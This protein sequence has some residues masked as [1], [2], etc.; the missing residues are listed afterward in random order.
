MRIGKASPK[1]YSSLVELTSHEGWNYSESDFLRLQSTGC[2]ETIV[3][4]E[5]GLVVGMITIMDYGDVAWIANVVVRSDLRGMG[6]GKALMDDAIARN[7]GKKTIA[8]LSYSNTVGFYKK[9]GF[10][11]E[12]KLSH[13]V[14]KGGRAGSAKE[15]T[16]SAD[17]ALDQRCFG[18]R[19]QGVLEMMMREYRALSPVK[20]RGFAFVRPDPV[21]PMVGPVIAD[22]KE[23]GEDL[24]YAALSMGG[25]GCGAVTPRGGL[26]HTE[27][28]AS[29]SMLYLGEKP[30]LDTGRVYALAGL[31]LG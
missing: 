11:E 17:L 31:E 8:L 7:G 1:D 18:Y 25:V 29:V 26:P 30:L 21:E 3:A 13:I 16:S 19:R 24:F 28:V 6:T 22:D 20:G 27:V 5:K 15:G 12:G 10:T 4:R 14:F 23:A 9:L 2:M